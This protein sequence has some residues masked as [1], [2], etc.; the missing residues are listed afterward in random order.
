MKIF[1]EHSGH[2]LLNHGD[3]A[4]L[5]TAVNRLK[6]K[7]PQSN[8]RILTKSNERLNKYCPGTIAINPD[9]RVAYRKLS[10]LR[11]FPDRLLTF[12][13]RILK[14]I[15]LNVDYHFFKSIPR[16]HQAMVAIRK[17]KRIK[18]A[19]IK[20]AYE[21]FNSVTSSD[22]VIAT[23]GGYINDTFKW[24]TYPKLETIDLGVK[25]KKITALLGQGIGPV[26]DKRLDQQM[27]AV[28]PNVDLISLREKRTSLPILIKQGIP[29]SKIITTGDD[30]I[31]MAYRETPPVIGNLVGVNLRTATYAGIDAQI[32][33]DIKEILHVFTQRHKVKYIP[34]AISNH[35]N[36][37]DK[38]AIAKIIKTQEIDFNA[39]DMID[40]PVKVIKCIGKCRIVLTGSYHAGVFALSQG[41]PV[42]GLAKSQYYKVKF[43]GLADQFNGG[44]ITVLLDDP[45]RKEMLLNSLEKSWIQSHSMRS[46]L[47]D[48]AQ[49]QIES[50][51]LIY[52]RLR[53]LAVLRANQS[54]KPA[55]I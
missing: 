18:D 1:I 28:L 45:Q 5:Q 4:M 12:F 42:V 10:P 46:V 31:E 9:T 20:K 25:F 43:Q 8:I 50:G 54:E 7:W 30:A 55:T 48:A 32:T 37:E 34:I 11:I 15:I 47:L 17:K 14:E 6:K 21:Y 53:E 49:K 22:M 27:R 52:E 3:T 19:D 38:E 29:L 44:C 51:R 16:C 2:E 13:P 35:E 39:L 23:G 26:S 41:I 40:S 36:G 24:H 33:N